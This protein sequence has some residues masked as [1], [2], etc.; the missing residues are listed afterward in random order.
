MFYKVL[1]TPLLGFV[2]ILLTYAL[3]Q[4]VYQRSVIFVYVCYAHILLRL[5]SLFDILK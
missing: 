2:T 4:Q 1:D 3:L 5:R